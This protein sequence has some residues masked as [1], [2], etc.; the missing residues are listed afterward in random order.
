MRKFPGCH[1]ATKI[2]FPYPK[3]LKLQL[4][5][6]RSLFKQD[7]ETNIHVDEKLFILFK[8]LF[9]FA[10]SRYTLNFIDYH[11]GSPKYSYLECKKYGI[12]YT[13]PIEAIFSIKINAT[14]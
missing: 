4:E 14:E 5:S 13:V 12:S 6:Y 7:C 1:N 3:L 9:Q 10:S 11:V 2:N 8:K